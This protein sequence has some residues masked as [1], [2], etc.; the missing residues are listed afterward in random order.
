MNFETARIDI[1]ERFCHRRRFRRCL[2]KAEFY[3]P[4]FKVFKKLYL[5]Q[6][7]LDLHKT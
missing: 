6:Y 3:V 4:Q 5:V 2:I 1:F 7:W